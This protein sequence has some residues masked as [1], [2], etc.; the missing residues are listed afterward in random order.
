M[1]KYRK[2]CLFK[3]HPMFQDEEEVIF[4][5]NF[6][7]IVI[8]YI[9]LLELCLNFLQ[10]YRNMKINNENNICINKLYKVVEKNES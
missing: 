5:Y 10:K 7:L 9:Y 6:Y 3:A 1:S 8:N 4:I 2:Y